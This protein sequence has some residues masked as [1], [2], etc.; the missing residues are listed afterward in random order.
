[1][2]I[3]R[4]IPIISFFTFVL[5]AKTFLPTQA[6]GVLHAK[7]GETV[8]LSE[9]SKN[10]GTLKWIIKGEENILET[11]TGR[12]FTYIFTE[13][14]EYEIVLNLSTNEEVLSSKIKVLVGTDYIMPVVEIIEEEK[15][16][17]KFKAILESLPEINEENEIYLQ[18]DFGQITLMSSSS[19]GDIAEYRI[20]K[21]IYF[22]SDENGDP[23]DD[24]DNKD[25]I[26]FLTGAPW[27][28]NYQKNWGNIVTK[29]TII[30][31]N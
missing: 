3:L 29:L 23:A 22:D 2:K 25:D 6:S 19:I 9:T 28:T 24:I 13:P 26:S 18:G 11:Q 8:I 30:S 21:N 12:N 7:V 10:V 17:A 27:T 31:E 4:R 16:S 1:M 20:D 14:G 5:F 15:E